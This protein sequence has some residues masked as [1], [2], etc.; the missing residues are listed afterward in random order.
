MAAVLESIVGPWGSVFIR[1]GVIASVL[2][3]QDQ[4]TDRRAMAVGAGQESWH[5]V[6]LG[7]RTH[8]ISCWA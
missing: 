8:S 2:G 7:G 6:R 4:G 1:V 5:V 3:G